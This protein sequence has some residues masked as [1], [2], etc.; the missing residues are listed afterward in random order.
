MSVG[1]WRSFGQESIPRAS[2]SGGGWCSVDVGHE[3]GN[4]HGR[5][6]VR[7]PWPLSVQGPSAEAAAPTRRARA[8]MDGHPRTPHIVEDVHTW[9]ICTYMHG[10]CREADGLCSSFF[11]G[12]EW[13]RAS[14]RDLFSV[15]QPLADGNA[16]GGGRLGRVPA[17]LRMRQSTGS[18]IAVPGDTA[19]MDS[20]RLAGSRAAARCH[21]TRSSP[22][23]AGGPAAR[24]ISCPSIHGIG[25]FYCGPV[26][27]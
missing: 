13:V 11:R 14:R 3:P 23:N 17:R 21:I 20:C 16:D 5:T 10:M 27:A 6:G 25:T 26:D 18:F 24:S 2:G 8:H 1:A 19:R 4:G 9:Y 12:V 22:P 15:W 7:Q